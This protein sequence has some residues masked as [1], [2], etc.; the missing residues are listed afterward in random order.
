[1]PQGAGARR[2]RAAPQD[3]GRLGL[4]KGP[5]LLLA[6]APRGLVPATF[7]P[8]PLVGEVPRPSLW[9][10]T[11]LRDPSKCSTNGEST[12]LPDPFPCQSQHFSLPSVSIHKLEKCTH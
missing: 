2:C 4:V 6:R 12:A 5:M 3:T 7:L 11:E 1:M 10:S 8:S 9:A